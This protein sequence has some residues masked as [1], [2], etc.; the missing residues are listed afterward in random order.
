MRRALSA[1]VAL[2]LFVFLAWIVFGG[3]ALIRVSLHMK[4]R[5]EERARTSL[6]EIARGEAAL[7]ARTTAYGTIAVLG[8]GEL[9]DTVLATG[10]K[11]GY[12]FVVTP[13]PAGF[14]AVA[15]P[16]DPGKTGTRVFSVDQGGVVR[17][18]ER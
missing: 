11:Q 1:V 13:T 17:D 16:S 2:G 9:I 7:H 3:T 18:G 6:E 14:S 8:S 15:R 4:E 5:N 12:F 10:T